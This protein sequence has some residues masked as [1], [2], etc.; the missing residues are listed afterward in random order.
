MELAARVAPAHTFWGRLRG[1]MLTSPSE[2]GDGQGL[3]LRPCRGIH[4][5]FMRFAFDAVYLDRELRVVYVV[6]SLRP[7]RMAATVWAA[8]SVLELPPGTVAATHTEAG[9]VIEI[10]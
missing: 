1:L 4:S 8:R 7:W 9:D 10:G 2:F 3:W 6:Q 5:F